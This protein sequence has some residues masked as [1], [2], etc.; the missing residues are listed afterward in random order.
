MS[1]E[2]AFTAAKRAAK[3]AWVV[4]PDNGYEGLG[5]PIGVWLNK[6]QARKDFELIERAVSSYRSLR[7]IEVPLVNADDD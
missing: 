1:E 7:L 3:L 2:I 4:M 5:E 6:D